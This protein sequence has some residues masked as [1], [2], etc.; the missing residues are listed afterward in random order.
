MLISCAYLTFAF[1]ELSLEGWKVTSDVSNLVVGDKS[2]CILT[3]LPVKKKILLLEANGD[4][5][6]DY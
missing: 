2:A 5:R 4:Y 3:Y 1:G 6:V